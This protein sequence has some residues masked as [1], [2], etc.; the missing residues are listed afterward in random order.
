M[1]GHDSV[2]KISHILNEPVNEKV[3]VQNG[4][5]E[6]SKIADIELEI[7]ERPS[8]KQ[9]ESPGSAVIPTSNHN[10]SPFLYTQFKSR[11]AAPFAPET[12]KSVDLVELP[13][14]VPARVFHEKTGL[15]Y[16][17]SPHSIP[18]FILAKKELPDP[19]KFYELVE[20]LG[21]VYGCVKLKIIP[22]ADKFTQLNVD[23]DR[24]WFKARKQSFNSNEFQRTKIVDFYAKLYNFHN[25]IK[26]STLTRIP[27]I[28]KRTLDLYRLRSCV[29]LRGG[30]NAVCEKIMGANWK[31][32]RL[33]GQDYEFVINFFKICLCK[34]FIRL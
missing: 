34:N 11:G 3:M 14:D 32:I 6:N 26:K 22:D 1:S 28:D 12:I 8:I 15:F 9:W 19:I 18:T 7:Q 16:Q 33:L 24:L 17:I 5:H 31:R 4:F 27:S 21:S 20:D 2:T 29:K 10:F 25:K 23:V 13:E 30:F